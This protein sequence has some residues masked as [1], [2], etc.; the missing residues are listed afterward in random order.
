MKNLIYMFALL[1]SVGLNAKAAQKTANCNNAKTA[2]TFCKSHPDNIQKDNG[3]PPVVEN[4]NIQQDNRKAQMKMED[5][6]VVF[7]MKDEPCKSRHFRTMPAAESF[8]RGLANNPDC[9]S[10]YIN[11]IWRAPL[12]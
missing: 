10:H 2:Q 5:I 7:C 12:I 4:R 6:T 3:V 11:H 1:S 8:T 9:L